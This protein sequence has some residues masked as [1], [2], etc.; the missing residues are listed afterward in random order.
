MS[1][2]REKRDVVASTWAALL[3][4]NAIV[5]WKIGRKPLKKNGVIPYCLGHGPRQTPGGGIHDKSLCGTRVGGQ[6]RGKETGDENLDRTRA[7][8]GSA[9]LTCH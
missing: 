8:R 1:I 9:E 4:L 3:Y 5:E 6:H 7:F 2:G